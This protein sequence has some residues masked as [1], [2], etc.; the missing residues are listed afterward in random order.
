M[1]VY[2]SRIVHWAKTNMRQTDRQTGLKR[3]VFIVDLIGL[4]RLTLPL[5]LRAFSERTG[6]EETCHE[7]GQVALSP[8][9]DPSLN[10]VTEGRSQC[11]RGIRT[12]FP[13]P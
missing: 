8:N 4:V 13:A 11:Q 10:K 6:G 2:I 5:S 9:G 3:L 7:L 1:S 12:S